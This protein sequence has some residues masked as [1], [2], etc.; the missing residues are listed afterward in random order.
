MR[1]PH[2][3]PVASTSAKKA[4]KT[5]AIN[6]KARDAKFHKEYADLSDAI[7]GVRKHKATPKTVS[8]KTT[9]PKTKTA[10]RD[11]VSEASA[12]TEM[13]K[14]V[15]LHIKKVAGEMLARNNNDYS[16]NE[17]YYSHAVSMLKGFANPL[18]LVDSVARSICLELVAKGK[19]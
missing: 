19:A 15:R 6:K 18:P 5:R 4:A 7:M 2:T 10:K 16:K 14:Y 12:Y 11:A 17:R 13:C 3:C 8:T 1:K 9:I